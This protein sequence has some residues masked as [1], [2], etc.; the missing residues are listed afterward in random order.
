[1][2]L[3]N[4]LMKKTQTPKL[5]EEPIL[6]TLDGIDLMIAKEIL[7]KGKEVTKET[8]LEEMYLGEQV[9]KVISAEVLQTLPEGLR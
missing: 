2:K 9:P 1:M 6:N 8:F 4:T 7:R 3:K 5:Q